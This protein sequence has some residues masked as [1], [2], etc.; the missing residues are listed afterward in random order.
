[1]VKVLARNLFLAGM[2]CS[3]CL[4]SHESKAYE[5]G[6]QAPAD[7]K[8]SV[9][10]PAST[11]YSDINF[12]KRLFLGKN[13]RKEWATP[14]KMPVFDIKTVNGGFTIGELGGGQQTKSLRL[15][16]KNGIEWVLRTV[17]K[18]VEKAI[19]PHLRKTFVRKLVQDMVS[20][21]HPYAPLTIPD[22]AK[23]A[24]VVAA[25]PVLYF[26]PDDPNLGEHRETFAN[27]VCML[28]KREPTPDNSDTDNSE[29]VLEEIMKE[30]DHLVMQEQVLRAR[31]L[32]MLIADWDRHIDQW[33]WG[34]VD[35]GET[36]HYYVIPRDRDFAY[37]DSRGLLVKFMTLVAVPH[38][39][40]FTDE[41]DKLKKLNKKTWFFD[42][43]FLNEL[44]AASWQRITA[45]FQKKIT[46]DVISR[47][48]KR[49]PPEVYA[50]SGRKIESKLRSRRDG[51]AK[52][53]MKY[54]KT[55][56]SSVHVMGTNKKDLFKI[57]NKGDD[58]LVEVFDIAGKEK[59]RLMYQ[60]VFKRSDTRE[61]FL[62]GFGDN[63][64][65]EIEEGADSRILLRVI[66]GDG[67]DSITNR[68]KVREKVEGVEQTIENALTQ[69]PQ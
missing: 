18:D 3:T 10:R 17:D 52:N 62:E 6:D 57:S 12:I 29:K 58:L 32:D 5:R 31:L 19:Q 50:I 38:M 67:K 36:K 45:E 68:G 16:D 8:D 48:V 44:D 25:S 30:N 24:N 60:R 23:A 7:T 53:V 2:W 35:S 56:A 22:L 9:I 64:H 39:R 54:Y 27:T 59:G 42:H 40:G 37:F 14:V 11:Q 20:A 63:D 28:E 65:F 4:I 49:M 33:R 13:Y 51:L 41:S 15:K 34:S 46:D 1:M 61:I 21:S 26:V 69:N 47:A 55:L 66:G 43:N